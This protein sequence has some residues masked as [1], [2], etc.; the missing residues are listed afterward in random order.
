MAL[1]RRSA[2]HGCGLRIETIYMEF[3]EFQA[4]HVHGLARIAQLNLARSTNGQTLL[5]DENQTSWYFMLLL[6]R[7]L[8]DVDD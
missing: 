6:T 3:F 1:Q 4:T 5:Y 2:N 8:T 7:E